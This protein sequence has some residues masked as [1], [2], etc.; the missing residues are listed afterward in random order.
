[1][2]CT[3]S[4]PQGSGWQPPSTLNLAQKRTAK[5]ISIEDVA[6]STRINPLYLRAIEAEDF[7]QLP[8]GIYA[9]SYVRQ[10]AAATGCDVNDVLA[11]YHSAVEPRACPESPSVPVP[12]LDLF[13]AP[14]LSH[15]R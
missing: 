2:N 9:V 13:L 11:R 14:R 5:N 12:V 4:T 6:N 8:G 15:H 10:Y 3:S 7:A 1:M